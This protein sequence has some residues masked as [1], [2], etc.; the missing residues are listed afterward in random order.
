MEELLPSGKFDETFNIYPS[1]LDGAGYSLNFETRSYGR[2]ASEN[3]LT[4]VEIYNASPS[5]GVAIG[6]Y[7]I[8]NRSQRLL[9][10]EKHGTWAYKVDVQGSGLIQL[11]LGFE[12]GW[13][14][15]DAKDFPFTIFHLPF[16]EHQK[17]DGWANGWLV[18]D[19]V[20]TIYI[21]YLPQ[22]LE[23][24]GMLMGMIAVILIFRKTRS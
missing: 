3:L 7:N 4:K 23:W 11:G 16:L 12:N 14:A 21:F 18:P 17:F 22:L 10:V 24:G 20:S 15:F 5:G 6:E 8:P 13:I 2:I 1:K 9:D 19:G